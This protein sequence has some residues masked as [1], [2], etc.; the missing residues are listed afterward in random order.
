MPD[1]VRHDGSDGLNFTGLPQRVCERASSL[2]EAGGAM[3]SDKVIG[4]IS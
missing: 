2:L 4:K 1:Q 3:V